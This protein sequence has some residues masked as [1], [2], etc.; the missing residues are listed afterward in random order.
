MNDCSKKRKDFIDDILYPTK[1][2]SFILEG[3][4][5]EYTV[6]NERFGFPVENYNQY[7]EIFSGL[8]PEKGK[9]SI[10]RHLTNDIDEIRLSEQVVVCSMPIDEFLKQHTKGHF[11]GATTDIISLMLDSRLAEQVDTDHSIEETTYNGTFYYGILVCDHLINLDCVH[12]I[13]ETIEDTMLVDTLVYGETVSTAE[14]LR[15]ELDMFLLPPYRSSN[16]VKTT[17]TKI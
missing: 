9:I 4:Y 8:E 12:L 10:I 6:I 16:I 1:I 13:I 3:C 2:Y 14:P 15:D 5:K 17:I 11:V 7:N